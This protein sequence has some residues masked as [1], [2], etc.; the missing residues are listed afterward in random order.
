MVWVLV[1]VIASGASLGVER[2][3]GAVRGASRCG[4]DGR[5]A[6]QVRATPSMGLEI[7]DAALQEVGRGLRY[8]PG[9]G[10]PGGPSA[11]GFDSTGLVLYAI[12][13]ATGYDAFGSRREELVRGAGFSQWVA[14]RPSVQAVAPWGTAASLP[15]PANVAGTYPSLRDGDVLVFSHGARVGIYV[16]EGMIVQ[17]ATAVGAAGDAWYFAGG[18]GTYPLWYLA[19]KGQQLPATPG[20]YPI[21]AVYRFAGSGGAAPADPPYRNQVVRVPATGTAYVADGHG[22]IHRIPDPLSYEYYVAQLGP[23]IDVSLARLATL[24]SGLPWALRQVRRV[25]A[26]DHILV[27]PATQ[28]WYLTD[29]SGQ[30][31]WIP[32]RSV[33]SCLVASGYGVVHNVAQSQIATLGTGL[34]WATCTLPPELSW[35]HRHPSR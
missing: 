30:L 26:A 32:T 29:A 3:G 7:A 35:I 25:D 20:E 2:A 23:P 13:Q 10:G 17:A 24:G 9:G 14:T 27:V 8:V 33:F 16:G 31:H 11:G 6:L 1:A 15:Y 28:R 19:G 18:V 12:Y 34:P 21:T 4:R 22:R 5:C